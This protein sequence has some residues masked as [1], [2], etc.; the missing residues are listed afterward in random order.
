MSDA[1]MDHVRTVYEASGGLLRTNIVAPAGVEALSRAAAAGDQDAARIVRMVTQ[2]T[3]QVSSAS[4]SDPVLCGC[5]SRPIRPRAWFVA[6]IVTPANGARVG[7]AALVLCKRCGRN[8]KTWTAKASQAMR[9][10]WPDYRVV[11][12]QGHAGGHA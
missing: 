5:C 1:V 6:C 3:E 2:V 4:P 11:E 8:P 9:R 7:A 12:T 10:I